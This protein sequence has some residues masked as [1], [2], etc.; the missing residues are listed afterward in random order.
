MEAL[1]AFLESEGHE[2]Y[3]FA[4]RFPG[5]EDTLASVRRFPS[6]VPPARVKFPLAIPIAP[7]AFREV[8]RLDLDLFHTHHPFGMGVIARRLARR[9]H[10]PLV[11]TIH[12][13]YEQYLHYIPVP[14]VISR[15]V[16]R[17]LVADYCNACQGVTTPARGMA[18]VVQGYGVR[19][20][21]NVVPNGVDL[22]RLRG[23]S[24][25]E[26]RRQ[27]GIGADQ[28]LGLFTGRIA[29]EKNLPAL[30]EM[31]RRVVAEYPGF[32]LLVL[33]DGPDLPA[34]RQQA[35]Q[36][37][38]AEVVLF[39][40]GVPHD[41]VP[42]FCAAADLFLTAST[43]EVNPTSVIEAMAAGTPV[44]AY[45]TFGAREIVAT[46][47]DG[48]LTEHSPEALTAAVASL[49]AEP[50]RLRRLAEAAGRAAERFS[51]EAT[52]GQMM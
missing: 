39:P 48:I 25:V 7:G 47:E 34:L 15:P 17:R 49:L 29:P 42:P 45:D 9:L 27:H 31:A 30:L 4:P 24:G 32:R 46:G 11:T 20:L 14:S 21:V 3:V 50:E 36:M 8:E 38:L 19:N 13:Q 26:V 1:R 12:T 22:R 35:G 23:A 43:T 16:V 40:G 28:V 10:V 5:Y 6:L 41:A 2:V 37:G 18:S 51:L 44:V 33:G 52:G